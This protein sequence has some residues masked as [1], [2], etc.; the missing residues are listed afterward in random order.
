MVDYYQQVCSVFSIFL[1]FLPRIIYGMSYESRFRNSGFALGSLLGQ[2]HPTTLVPGYL[3]S[4]ENKQNDLYCSNVSNVIV[5]SCVCKI[6]RKEQLL[7]L[8]WKIQ[9]KKLFDSL[10]NNLQLRVTES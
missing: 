3:P 8:I 4:R 5:F 1:V 2:Q 7:I 6:H 10:D 9:E